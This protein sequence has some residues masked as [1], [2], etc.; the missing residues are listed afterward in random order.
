MNGLTLALNWLSTDCNYQTA[1]MT[2]IKLALP[3]GAQAF[4]IFQNGQSLSGLIFG[5]QE[6]SPGLI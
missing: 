2:L 4:F 3:E 6:K 5:H 1:T